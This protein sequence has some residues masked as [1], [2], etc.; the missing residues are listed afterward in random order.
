MIES[1]KKWIVQ[2]PNEN[3]IARLQ[4]DLHISSLA[5]K[6]LVARGFTSSED[7]K[8]ILHTNEKNLHDPFLLHGMKEAVE[9]IEVA[10][11]NGEKILVYGDYDADGITSTTVMLNVLLDLGA[12]VD[13][14][15]PNRF[16]HG[17]GPHEE[18]F[19][20][21][22]EDGVQLIITVDNGISGIEPIRIAK[23]LGMDVIVTDHHEAGEELPP[24]DVIVHPR[25]P[26]GHYPFG[27][28]AGVGV[29][30]K[31]AH[32][33]Y[34][35]VPEHLFEYA[36]V[37]T[38]AD[39]V[40][41]VGENRYIVQQGILQL[42][43]SYNPW[44]RAL[45]EIS[46]IKQHEIDE[47]AIGFYFAPRLNAIG[48][49]GDAD[50]GV[51]F[52]MS[53]NDSDAIQGAQQLNKKNS[54]RKEI[55][56]TITE[57]AI[58][59][60]ENDPVISNSLVIVVAK[61]GWN[62][63][64]IGIVAS[65]LIEKYYR[66][67]IV[68]S[69]DPNLGTAKG[70][71]RSIEGFHLYNE[72]AKNRDIL[73]HFGGH[74]MAAGMTFG[75][76]YVDELRQRLHEQAEQ[77][78][79]DDLLEP[80]LLVDVPLEISEISVESIEEIKKLAPFGTGFAKPVYAL[81]NVKVRSMR[82]IG[83]ADNHI[84]LELED[85]HGTIDAIGFNKG[86]LHDEITYG[87]QLS[88]VGDL[89]INE[90]QGNKKPQIMISDVQTDEWQL[91]DYRGKKPVQR[92]INTLPLTQ[93]A[94]LA[95]QQNTVEY[96]KAM[97]NEPIYL[98]GEQG[99]DYSSPYIV[100]LD[101]PQNV[102]MLEMVIKQY[103]PKRIYAV[104]FTQDSQFFNGMPT[105]EHFA[106]Y[107]TFLK[108]RPAFHLQNHMQQL[109]QHI[110]LN[111]EVIKFMTNVFFELGFVKIENGLTTINSDA[112]KRALTDASIYKKRVEQLEIEQKLLYAPYLELKQWFN[113]RMKEYQYS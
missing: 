28:L 107:Y 95:F 34:G 103:E 2:Q 27:E 3:D 102:E 52:L 33:L 58:D 62:P 100:L 29:A 73:P 60:I 22:Y 61:E 77:C 38:V 5:A 47:D 113:E 85:S 104:F 92:W 109:S 56:N 75:M 50:P 71:G 76:E 79:T 86:Y 21:A 54:E 41:L 66:P 4:N 17:Y 48:R 82:K 111:I 105:R 10:L 65:R 39:L 32:A 1:K 7:A 30:L 101:L 97:I 40:P 108:K 51:H 16:T 81:Q 13:F 72:L 96:F 35:E 24:A 14:C 90:W 44:I 93:C 25:V 88:F 37:G 11:E 80:K 43:S 59:M 15:I 87:V 74:P 78:L 26:E 55:V 42:R 67:T 20:K 94:L 8:S 91:Y 6:I 70:S 46:G 12:N 69:L 18:L 64:V 68:L 9:R 45:C 31:L 89:Q 98:V 53:E 63:G 106:W 49:L 84:K 19:R 83:A 99:T 112:P 23:E 110:G 57:Q 36:A